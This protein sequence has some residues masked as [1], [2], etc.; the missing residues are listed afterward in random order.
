M[1]ALRKPQPVDVFPRLYCPERE[2]RTVPEMDLTMRTD[3]DPEMP[4]PVPET[5]DVSDVETWGQAAVM[6]LAAFLLGGLLAG[7]VIFAWLLKNA[8]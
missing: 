6:N 1:G 3:P 5:V 7:L 2:P 4:P 8:H